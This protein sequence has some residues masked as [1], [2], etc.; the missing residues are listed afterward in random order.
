[1]PGTLR[2]GQVGP[3]PANTE[4]ENAKETSL[5]P[6]PSAN[7][8]TTTPKEFP[9]SFALKTIPLIF[10]LKAKDAQASTDWTGTPLILAQL[11]H[12]ETS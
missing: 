5:K 10:Q 2:M 7:Q 1:M 12:K 6:V 4:S 9:L 8:V 3:S 11:D